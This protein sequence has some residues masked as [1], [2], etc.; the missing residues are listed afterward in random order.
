MEFV[1]ILGAGE[2]G[3]GAAILA[4]QKG[5]GVWVSD[6]GV[7]K[8]K[9]K[10]E[11]TAFGID[12]E[13]NGHDEAKILQAD[14]IV[15]SPGIPEKAPII[16][17]LRAENKTIISEI[18]WAYRFI[19]DSK[20]VAITGSNGKSTTTVL[21]YDVFKKAGYDTALVGNIGISF[22][23][24]V[25]LNPVQ[26]YIIE[27]SSF[28]LDD[29]VTFRPF[30]AVLLNI[31]PD[32]LDRY[33]YDFDEYVR[34]K[35]NIFKNQKPT[36]YAVINVDDPSIQ[37]QLTQTKLNSQL[38]SITMN[39]KLFNNKDGALFKNN[40]IEVKHNNESY[41]QSVDDMLIKGQHNTYN[42]MAAGISAKV[43]GIRNEFLRESFATFN[44][45]E[46][47]L[48]YVATV[49]GVEF[50]NDSKGTNLN[51]VWYALESMDKKVILILGGQDK[52]NDYNEIMDLVQEKVKAIVCLGINNELIHNAFQSVI[53]NI[54]DTQSA[55]DAV[56]AAYYLATEGDVVLLSPGCASFDLFKNFEDRGEQFKKAVREL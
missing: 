39:E 40:N 36:D 2:S 14:I 35:F 47:R 22:A 55:T 49:R 28:Q 12:F 6:F 42:T 27:V 25:A 44:G 21:T 11:L 53:H 46:H 26:W 15:K 10:K 18:E 24:Q 13:E 43:A 30:V 20:I 7:I 3:N 50:I 4:K 48:E 52:G 32:H 56:Q 9:Y 45:L 37:K 23:K 17:K 19:G 1:V 29:I 41:K 51:S 33:N 38:L 34:S 5:Y 8:E 16:K 54:V 31:T